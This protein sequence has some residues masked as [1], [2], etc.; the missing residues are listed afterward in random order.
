[1][2]FSRLIL[3]Q[4]G[5]ETC[6]Q[7]MEKIKFADLYASQQLIGLADISP[8]LGKRAGIRRCREG[9]GLAR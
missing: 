2:G 5:F 9:G 1:M 3:L 6:M 4:T 7:A 8:F